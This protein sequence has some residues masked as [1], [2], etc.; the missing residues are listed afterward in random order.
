[1]YPSTKNIL[2][3]DIFSSKN[4]EYLYQE[5]SIRMFLTLILKAQNWKQSNT[6]DRRRDKYIVIYVYMECYGAVKIK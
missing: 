2:L 6:N 4:F 3:L 1:M 5:I